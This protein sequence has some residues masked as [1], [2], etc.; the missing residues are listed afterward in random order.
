MV[1]FIFAH[2]GKR[3]IIMNQKQGFSRFISVLLILTFAATSSPAAVMALP[4]NQNAQ[5][6]FV[7][8]PHIANINNPIAGILGK[9]NFTLDTTRQV[10]DTYDPSK[11]YPSL[12]LSVTDANGYVW[13][14]NVPAG[15]LAEK[16]KITMTA[17]ATIDYSQSIAKIRSGVLLEPD[18][19]EFS[20]PATLRVIPPYTNPG[21][22]L[23]FTLDQDGS[24][25]GFAATTNSGK[26]AD[27]LI[28]HFSG[29]GYDD[30][31]NSGQTAADVYRQMGEE[32]YRLAVD[33]A[34]WYLKSSKFTPPT[35]PA[36]SMFCRGTEVNPEQNEVYEYLQTFMDPVDLIYYNLL[37][38]MYILSLMGGEDFSQ[39][40]TLAQ[41]LLQTVLTAMLKMGNQ[42]KKD[43]K[44]PDH[45]FAV[46][47]ATIKVEKMFQLIGGPEDFGTITSWAATIR[48]YYLDQIKTKHD[49]RAFPIVITLE[50]QAQLLGA[51]DR[52]SEIFSAMT[53][54][55]K[56]DTIFDTT[57]QPSDF[58]FDVGHVEQKADVKSIKLN[59]NGGGYWG[60]YWGQLDNLILRY[61][62]G[63]LTKHEPGKTTTYTLD[64]GQIFTSTV[65]LLNFD[66]CVTKTFDVQ[67]LSFGQ[68]ETFT[69][70][71][72]SIVNSVAGAGG[73]VAFLQYGNPAFQFSVPLQNLSPNLG[74]KTFPGSGKTTGLTASATAHI[75]IIH[76]P[77]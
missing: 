41:Q 6:K 39:G 53:F 17:F 4:L 9:L 13:W 52:L 68:S 58:F 73:N 71:G 75:T 77:Q 69:G 51:P 21:I 55:V 48:D 15:A 63:T 33:A 46:V 29:A 76:T 19:L 3:R 18:G 28:W 8:L 70:G 72:K 25:V 36:V 47:F 62:T 22:G 61:T 27:A 32:D 26:Q 65:Y 44:P 64:P 37:R 54:E 35:P 34:K 7:Y 16:Q 74:E 12:Y 56:F 10:S 14:L 67:V 50:K 42:Y 60:G 30:I 5:D 59:I 11:D 45:L 24:N 49:Y 43:E 66:A 2:G 23:V 38:S 31:H 40:N 20:T 57:R 1:S